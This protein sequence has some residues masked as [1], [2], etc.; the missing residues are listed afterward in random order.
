MADYIMESIHDILVGESKAISDSAS[1]QG[2]YHPSRECF[3]TEITGDAC[4]E[5]TLEGRIVNDDDGTP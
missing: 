5:V 3:M 4:Q 2:S 1:S